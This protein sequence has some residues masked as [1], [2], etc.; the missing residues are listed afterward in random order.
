MQL[1]DFLG[2]FYVVSIGLGISFVVFTTEKIVHLLKN[3][4]HKKRAVNAP[5]E[6]DEASNEEQV[7]RIHVIV[8]SEMDLAAIDRLTEEIDQLLSPDYDFRGILHGLLYT[9]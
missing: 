5:P 7:H 4:W 1:G 8:P 2:L 9:K 6:D 3:W